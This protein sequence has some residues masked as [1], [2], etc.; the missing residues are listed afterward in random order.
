MGLPQGELAELTSG[1]V[2]PAPPFA[3][4]AT[5]AA[6]VGAQNRASQNHQKVPDVVNREPVG[7]EIVR[8]GQTDF[9]TVPFAGSCR[10]SDP[11]LV[12]LELSQ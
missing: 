10:Y 3:L 11:A 9:P 8:R 1:D 12:V 2:L 6:A 5:G 7:P 4:A